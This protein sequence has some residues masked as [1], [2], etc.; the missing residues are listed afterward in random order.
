[1][2][3]FALKIGNETL[4]E[5]WEKGETLTT[6]TNLSWP[7]ITFSDSANLQIRQT[8]IRYKNTRRLFQQVFLGFHF[9]RS[10]N[11]LGVMAR[12][13]FTFNC[14]KLRDVLSM[15]IAEKRKTLPVTFSYAE[16]K[17]GHEQ[18]EILQSISLRQKIIE[19][20]RRTHFYGLQKIIKTSM[21]ANKGTSNFA[22][23][24]M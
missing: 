2:S 16:G 24:K 12:I 19:P 23:C 9:L 15:L 8:P 20:V 10:Q 5:S 17:P 14:A 6:L 11:S 13:Q 1:M 3:P 7:R 18:N 22:D 21:Q 4:F